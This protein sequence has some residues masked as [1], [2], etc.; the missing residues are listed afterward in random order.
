MANGY[1]CKKLWDKTSGLTL[2]Y[3]EGN[4]GFY[5]E[6]LRIFKPLEM[7][8]ML[9][10]VL[11][12]FIITV[13]V[14]AGFYIMGLII[15]DT[16]EPEPE[17]YFQ[18]VLTIRETENADPI[19]FL[20]AKG[21]YDSSFWGTKLKIRGEITNKATVAEYKDVTLRVTYFSKTKSVLGTK[22]YTLYEVYP[23]NSSTPFRLDIENYKDVNSIGWEV[24]SAL[25]Y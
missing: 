16:K 21:N 22:E 10:Q 7:N 6:W 24:I 23:A 25:T 11:R 15:K 1:E 18:Q 20:N 4:K 12:L 2:E 19:R 5:F 17:S 14:I 9:K 13:L 3:E 8:T